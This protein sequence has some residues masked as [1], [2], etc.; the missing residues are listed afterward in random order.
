MKTGRDLFLYLPVHAP[1]QFLELEVCSLFEIRFHSPLLPV[2]S[3]GIISLLVVNWL[4]KKNLLRSSS[5]KPNIS[6]CC[7]ILSH[8]WDW[9]IQ[10]CS[11][12]SWDRWSLG[13]SNACSYCQ[14]CIEMRW[15]DDSNSWSVRLMWQ[16]LF[17]VV[18]TKAEQVKPIIDT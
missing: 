13:S 15:A 18:S 11:A 5:N 7:S 10:F 2:A 16:K 8:S 4:R 17:Q 6:G 3:C 14:P 9:R 1:P 12:H